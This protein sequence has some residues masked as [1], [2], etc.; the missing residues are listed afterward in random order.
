MAILDKKYKITLCYT[1][2][3]IFESDN[4][5]DAIKKLKEL[6][7]NEYSD[8]WDYRQSCTENYEPAAD[9]SLR[10]I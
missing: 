9:F 3:V 5:S 4:K 8:Y 6:E 2:E 7:G 1:D 10:I